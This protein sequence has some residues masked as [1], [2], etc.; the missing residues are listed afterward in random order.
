MPK[1]RNYPSSYDTVQVALAHNNHTACKPTDGKPVGLRGGSVPQNDRSP[2]VISNNP[3]HIDPNRPIVDAGMS[4]LSAIV[5]SVYVPNFPDELGHMASANASAN[6]P[7]SHNRQRSLESLNGHMVGDTASVNGCHGQHIGPYLY[8][9]SCVDRRESHTYAQE[10]R[11]GEGHAAVPGRHRLH[12][13]DLQHDNNMEGV[14]NTDNSVVNR[15]GNGGYLP[16]AP[17]PA[18]D[19]HYEHNTRTSPY[20][21]D[22]QGTQDHSC[23]PYYQDHRYNVGFEA[24]DAALNTAA[25]RGGCLDN[26]D[27]HFDAADPNHNARIG[28]IAFARSHSRGA[29]GPPS[30]GVLRNEATPHNLTGDTRRRSTLD[31]ACRGSYP[32]ELHNP[33]YDQPRLAARRDFQG[34]R[35]RSTLDEAAIRSHSRSPAATS[36]RPSTQ[37]TRTTESPDIKDSPLS[38][39]EIG[40]AHV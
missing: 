14:E 12:S 13:S 4:H 35:A 23:S 11:Q 1:A 2:Q 28:S 17:R 18:T 30:H 34:Y 8:C 19:R 10:T 26:R 3:Q 40:R 22:Y 31:Q 36:S 15:T 29:M 21:S 16:I 6:A 9:Q 25:I 32:Q 24:F 39:V 38:S 33:R 5:S 37:E 27:Q 7:I 20:S